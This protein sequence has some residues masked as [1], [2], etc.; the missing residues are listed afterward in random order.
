M[1]SC[2]TFKR[3]RLSRLLP[4]TKRA[5]A[6]RSF[7]P[8]ARATRPNRPVAFRSAENPE[9]SPSRSRCGPRSFRAGHSWPG[10]Q[11]AHR[12]T[13]RWPPCRATAT[14]GRI[15]L[16]SWNAPILTA[17]KDRPWRFLRRKPRNC[18]TIPPR[19]TLEGAPGPG[20]IFGGT[21]G[22]LAAG[23][24]CGIASGRSASEP[25]IR[26]TAHP[27]QRWPARRAGYSF[28]DRYA[29]TG[30]PGCRRPRCRSGWAVIPAPEP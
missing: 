17:R 25:R 10:S 24:D 27:A 3:L 16:P 8:G 30:I 9:T 19:T 23:G 15:T 12:E 4:E 28:S 18:S 11:A 13:V 7:A 20:D 1:R 14:W 5:A 26:L 29:Y 2:R 21:A 22:G 6:E